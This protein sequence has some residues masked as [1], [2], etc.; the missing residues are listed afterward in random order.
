M[1]L[2]DHRAVLDASR[3]LTAALH[4]VGTAAASPTAPARSSTASA[5]PA[6]RT[7]ATRSAWCSPASRPSPPW[8]R[9]STTRL[10]GAGAQPRR[11][12]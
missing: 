12:R 8:P 7:A 11:V 9:R 5:S 10:A 6:S 1:T 3:W 2:E 4:H